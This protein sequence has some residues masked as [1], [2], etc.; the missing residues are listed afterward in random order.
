V[1]YVGVVADKPGRWLG[2]EWDD[3]VRGKHDGTHDGVTYF[4]C[5]ELL[6]LDKSRNR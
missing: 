1:R 6:H 5:N 3:P 4:T 2:V